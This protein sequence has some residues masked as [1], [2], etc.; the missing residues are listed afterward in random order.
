MKEKELITINVD[1]L[2]TA[3]KKEVLTWAKQVQFI[4]QNKALARKEKLYALKA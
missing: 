3:E 1:A 4:Q 2:D